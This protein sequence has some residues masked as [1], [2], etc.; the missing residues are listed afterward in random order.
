[1]SPR[2]KAR[3]VGT[4][5]LLVAV[6]PLA[7]RQLVVRFDVNPWKL[8]GFA[9]YCTPHDIAVDLIDRSGAKPSKIG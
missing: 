3:V 9:M 2:A 5:L 8:Y 1:M 6:W 7:H 4:L